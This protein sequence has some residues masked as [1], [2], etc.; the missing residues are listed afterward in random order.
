MLKSYKVPGPSKG[1]HHQGSRR[2][3][4][5]DMEANAVNVLNR[6]MANNPE[7]ELAFATQ[8]MAK[9]FGSQDQHGNQCRG[10]GA[11]EGARRGPGVSAGVS[12]D[13]AAQEK[14]IG[15]LSEMDQLITNLKKTEEL[16]EL[17]G[18]K[19][20]GWGFIRELAGGAA[21]FFRNTPGLIQSN[22]NPA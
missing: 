1:I 16:R 17:M 14:K 18:G 10:T 2:S 9:K 22:Q 4:I 8:I 12:P 11:S 3:G 15:E 21:E 6:A 5:E 20:N 19:D 13:Q 7:M